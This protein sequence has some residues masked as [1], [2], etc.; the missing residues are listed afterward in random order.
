MTIIEPDQ[1][2]RYKGIILIHFIKGQN[3]KGTGHYSGI[4]LFI[5][6]N[7]GSV[8]FKDFEIKKLKNESNENIQMMNKYQL[9]T[10]IINSRSLRDIYKNLLLIDIL[11]SKDIDIALLQETFLIESDKLYFEGYKV[12]RGDNQV[13]RKGVAILVSVK[14]DIECS[15]IAADPNAVDM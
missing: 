8:T 1:N 9:N 15:K 14:L 5:Q 12:Y 13:R 10:F 11:R 7:L 6:H 2:Q 4:K 3:S